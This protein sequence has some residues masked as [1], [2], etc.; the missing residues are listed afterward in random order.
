MTYTEYNPNVLE[1]CR[2]DETNPQLFENELQV[3][4]QIF[5]DQFHAAV[6]FPFSFTRSAAYGHLSAMPGCTARYAW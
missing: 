2:S 1:Q 4:L 5:E 6:L 3:F